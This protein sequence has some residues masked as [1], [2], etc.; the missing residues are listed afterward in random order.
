MI[1]F[2]SKFD[3]PACTEMMKKYAEE[4][5]IDLLRDNKFHDREYTKTLLEQLIVGRGFVLL[6]DQMR[7]MLAAVITPN[8]W[9]PKVAEIK[10]VAWWVH[11]EY[12]Q[13]TIGGRLFFEFVKHSEE[14]VRQKRADIVCASLMHISSVQTLPGFKKIESTFVKE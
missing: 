3:V 7:G 5:P 10:E 14:L 13:G 9:C 11:P 1:R 6:D 4:S 8:F 12:R 2:A